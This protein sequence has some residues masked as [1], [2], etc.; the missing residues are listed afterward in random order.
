MSHFENPNVAAVAGNVKV[1][2]EVNLLTKW[3][4]IEYIISQNFERKAFDTINSITVIPGAI[5]AF[6]KNVLLDIGGFTTDTLAEDC[7]VTIKILKKGYKIED[8]PKAIA[9]TEVPETLN[10]FLKQRFRWTFGV[11]QTFWKNK[12]V[13]FNTNYKT[14]GWIAF[15]DI[16]LFKYI[17][18]LFSP[19][20]DLLMILGFFSGNAAKIGKFYLLFLLID[21]L[22]ALL[23]FSY[24]KENIKKI[25]WIIPQRIIYRWLMLYVLFKSY[26]RAIKGEL[27]SW[28]ILKR[29]GNV[30]V[31]KSI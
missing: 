30:T 9:L 22:I 14:L 26:R 16:L 24:E 12:K 3:Q 20:A 31:S 10:Q 23:V 18:P 29:T 28:G 6:R 8:E 11:M 17:I 2:N 15:P 21:L 27:Q 1:G 4:S 19:I 25:L 13:L 5:G 7:D